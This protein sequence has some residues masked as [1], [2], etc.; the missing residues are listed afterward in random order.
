MLDPHNCDRQTHLQTLPR[1]P[2][3]QNHSTLRATGPER[4]NQEDVPYYNDI[5]PAPV[6]RYSWAQA[7]VFAPHG[8]CSYWYPALALGCSKV[9]HPFLLLLCGSLAGWQDGCGQVV[10]HQEHVRP[11]RPEALNLRNG[12]LLLGS[13]RTVSSGRPCVG[14]GV[15]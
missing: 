8:H 7:S 4:Q 11:H 10:S 6:A 15:G 9:Q 3:G 14:L 1:V 2:G 12:V 5:C 13:W